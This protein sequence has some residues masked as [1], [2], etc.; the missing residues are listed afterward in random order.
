MD[1]KAKNAKTLVQNN[2]VL[3]LTFGFRSPTVWGLTMF[4]VFLS[5]AR[6]E[7][8]NHEASQ[9]ILTAKIKDI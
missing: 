1:I 3:L 8:I 2:T 5:R 9:G 6:E 7:A 4:K